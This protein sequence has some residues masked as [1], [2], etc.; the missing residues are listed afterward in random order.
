MIADTT[1][2]QTVLWHVLL[3]NEEWAQNVTSDNKPLWSDLRR[4]AAAKARD[5]LR[6]IGASA[7]EKGSIILLNALKE[8][9]DTLTNYRGSMCGAEICLR[10]SIQIW[11][12]TKA[13][14]E[15]ERE[16]A[17]NTL[18]HIAAMHNCPEI[19]RFANGE[20]VR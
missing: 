5:Y 17:A 9:A 8:C 15:I 7:D 19:T 11:V 13:V 3:F 1:L 16:D 14:Q 2:E 12:L 18:R 6:A 10:L 20:T 4:N